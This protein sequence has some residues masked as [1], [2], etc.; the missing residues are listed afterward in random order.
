MTV[1]FVAVICLD[2]LALAMDGRLR[3]EAE[4]DFEKQKWSK[5]E[6]N[7]GEMLNKINC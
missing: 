1:I 3:M 7:Y 5:K 6:K 2:H 4:S